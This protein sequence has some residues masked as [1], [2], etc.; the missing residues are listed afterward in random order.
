MCGKGGADTLAVQDRN[1]NVL[2]VKRNKRGK[3][4]RPVSLLETSLLR[5][6]LS[7]LPR[8]KVQRTKKPLN[9]HVRLAADGSLTVF[10]D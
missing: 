6:T 8:V 10:V 9:L 2:G 1:F 7:L 3:L 4:N 5:L